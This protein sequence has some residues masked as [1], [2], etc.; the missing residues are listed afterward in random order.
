MKES[1]IGR[2]GHHD[3]EGHLPW[4]SRD[5]A[6]V[7]CLAEGYLFKR[8]NKCAVPSRWAIG[9]DGRC[10]GFEAQVNY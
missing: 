2:I 9:E 3:P 6:D 1:L 7:D 4:V 5:Y 8:G 10:R